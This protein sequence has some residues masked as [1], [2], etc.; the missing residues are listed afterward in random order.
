[1][2][3]Y[4]YRMRW[5]LQLLLHRMLR[6][7]N[8]GV[9]IG[10]VVKHRTRYQVRL[11]LANIVEVHRSC[12]EWRFIH[13]CFMQKADMNTLQLLFGCVQANAASQPFTA[14]HNSPEI[15]SPPGTPNT[16]DTERIMTFL[17]RTR[18][19]CLHFE[20]YTFIVSCCT[21]CWALSGAICSILV[22]LA[23]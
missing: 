19:L 4:D 7:R 3:G 2:Q 9:P 12:S 14:G 23:I 18:T 5:L 13:M 10:R 11:G 16:L 20:R 17:S 22:D 8:T 15:G 1:M 6:G 21:H